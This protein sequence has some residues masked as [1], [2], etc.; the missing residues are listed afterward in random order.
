MPKEAISNTSPIQYLFQA[1]CFD[2]LPQLYESVI[3]PQGVASEL[4]AGQALGVL[5]PDL[6]AYDWIQ[7]QSA[8]HLEILPLAADLGQG[9]REVLSLAVSRPEAVALLDDSLARHFGKHLGIT[10]T[11]TLGV[12]LKA[13]QAGHLEVIRPKL[14][15]LQQLGFRLS[16][17]THFTVLDIAGER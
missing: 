17:Q 3:V 2:I 11:G 6:S 10:L 8:P 15:R 16:R 9:E 12:L 5:L 13:K 4:A 1:D 14:D 7:I